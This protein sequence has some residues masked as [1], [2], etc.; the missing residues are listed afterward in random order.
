MLSEWDKRG[1]AGRNGD[2]REGV[3]D[4]EGPGVLLS[5][6]LGAWGVGTKGLGDRRGAE[7]ARKRGVE[8]RELI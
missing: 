1:E 2:G 6:P 8:D 5:A 7:F 4:A 3:R